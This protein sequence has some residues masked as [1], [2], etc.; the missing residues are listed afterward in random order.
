MQTKEVG[1]KR[2]FSF[3]CNTI[4]RTC[5]CP[6]QWLS[7]LIYRFVFSCTYEFDTT[8]PLQIHCTFFHHFTK[9]KPRLCLW[10]WGNWLI[11]YCCLCRLGCYSVVSAVNIS[12]KRTS[13]HVVTKLRLWN[14]TMILTIDCWTV[15]V[16]PCPNVI[17]WNP[18][19]YQVGNYC[20][21]FTYILIQL[22]S[23][24]VY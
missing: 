4:K 5:H 1:M 22:I 15:K 9:K 10:H 13:E 12:P 17:G 24:C 7:R 19:N 11:W 18:I 16:V 20:L 3:V 23:W 6:S 21:L 14:K 8:L 2:H